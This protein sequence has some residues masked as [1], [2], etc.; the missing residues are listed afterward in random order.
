MTVIVYFSYVSVYYNK[1]PDMTKILYII[2]KSNWGGA[3]RYVYDMATRAAK[4]KVN[5]ESCSVKV[6]LGGNGMLAQTLEAA[7]IP[8]IRI[9]GLERDVNPIKDFSVFF[10][11]IS[12]LRREQPDVLHVNS[13]KIGAMGA[14]AGRIA[15]IPKIIFTAH[16]WAFNEDRGFISKLFIKI[17]YWCAI[18]FSHKTITVSDN[19]RFK[20]KHWPFIGGKTVTVHNGVDA[21]AYFAKDSARVVLMERCPAIK[22]ALGEDWNKPVWIGTIAELHPIKSL[23][24]AIDAISE[25]VKRGRKV[26]YTIIGE[27]QERARLEKRIADLGLSKHVFLTGHIDNAA[28]YLKAFDIFT[29]VSI[30]EGLAYVVIEAGMAGLPVIA[31][32]V[33]GVPELVE[34][35]KSGLLIQPRK[36]TEIA[37]SI[38]FMIEHRST[39]HEYAH[40]LQTK[41]KRDFS[42][43]TMFEKTLNLYK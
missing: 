23:D 12:L 25:V 35:M 1:T 38:E 29:L 30:S 15:R 13:S 4:E 19:M 8:V 5:G 34:D 42:V 33:G 18:F 7:G 36:P 31:T 22:S 27:G 17:I 9:D 3:Q 20:I 14:V 41:M 40:E 16:G 6:A 26:V 39:A 11:L 28:Q 37:K 2:T 43:E 10:K 21:P 32:A 24:T